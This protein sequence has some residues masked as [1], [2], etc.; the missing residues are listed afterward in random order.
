MIKRNKFVFAKSYSLL[1]T[2]WQRVEKLENL[3][4]GGWQI[5]PV[6]NLLTRARCLL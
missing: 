5:A 2:F 1:A 6:L 4:K 3:L